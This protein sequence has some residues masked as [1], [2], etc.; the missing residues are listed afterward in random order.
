MTSSKRRS[1]L[2]WGC[3]V[4]ERPDISVPLDADVTKI[5][6]VT[7]Q[8]GTGFEDVYW[9]WASDYE[10]EPVWQIEAR[11]G[12]DGYLT[13][14]YDDFQSAVNQFWMY[15]REATSRIISE[16]KGNAD[17]QAI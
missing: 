16:Q 6:Q 10:G 4:P 5:V 15:V 3:P 12:Y 2:S 17:G 7:I 11:G 8:P 1:L 9:L 14:V 13:R